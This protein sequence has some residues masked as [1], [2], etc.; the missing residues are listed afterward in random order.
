M[1][2]IEEPQLRELPGI[3]KDLAR[4]IREIA[5]TGA[6]EY[7]DELLQ[8]FPST[9]PELLRLAAHFIERGQAIEEIKGRVLQSLGHDRPGALLKFQ[10]EVHMLGARFLVKAE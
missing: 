2:R 6:C 8:Q 9:I 5:T 1:T 3:G 7:H 10:D 4:K